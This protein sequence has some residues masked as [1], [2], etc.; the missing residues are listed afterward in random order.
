[1]A[2]LGPVAEPAPVTVSESE[3]SA[4]GCH[5]RRVKLLHDALRHVDPAPPHSLL[6]L[7]GPSLSHTHM[8]LTQNSTLSN[9][10]GTLS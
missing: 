10:K 4:V 7:A 2:F 5:H 1:M 8:F 3:N 6:N 9:P